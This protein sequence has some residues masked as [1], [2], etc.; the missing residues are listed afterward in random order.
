[1]GEINYYLSFQETLYNF[2]FAYVP[3]TE[4]AFPVSYMSRGTSLIIISLSFA[5]GYSADQILG[6]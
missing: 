2:V 3:E 6:K 4:I 5:T 1:M